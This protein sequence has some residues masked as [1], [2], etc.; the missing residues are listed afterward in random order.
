M[1]SF[2]LACLV[3]ENTAG[4][5]PCSGLRQPG[6]KPPERKFHPNACCG[7]SPYDRDTKGCCKVTNRD[8]PV[9]FTK[10]YQGCCG[11]HIIDLAG[12]GCCHSKPHNLEEQDCCDGQ[13]QDAKIFPG[14]RCQFTEWNEWSSCAATLGG[15]FQER[16]RDWLVK[17]GRP[18]SICP[19]P[20]RHP[21]YI[22]RERRDGTP[23]GTADDLAVNCLQNTAM[24]LSNGLKHAGKY[25]DLV[26]LLD[27]STSIKADNFEYAK[28]LVNNIVKSLCGGVGRYSNRV[29]VVR[30]SADV[31]IDIPFNEDMTTEDVTD[32]VSKFEYQPIQSDKH[33]GSTYTAAAMKEVYEKV[34]SKSNGWRMGT[35]PPICSGVI[36][37]GTCY[38]IPLTYVTPS[39]MD[40]VC[41]S[42][43]NEGRPAVLDNYNSYDMVQQLI[44]NTFGFPENDD[45]REGPWAGM[46]VLSN[47]KWEYHGT[48]E[49]VWSELTDPNQVE[50]CVQFAYEKHNGKSYNLRSVDCNRPRRV[51]CEQEPLSY[52]DVQTELLLITDGRSNDPN[53]LGITLEEMKRIY[54]NTDINVSA[55][56]VGRIN[57]EEIRELTSHQ[58][59]HIFYLMSWESVQKFNRIFEKVSKKFEHD[60]CLPLTVAQEDIA[61]VKWTK[62][63]KG[64]GV[65]VRADQ[66]SYNPFDLIE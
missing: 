21:D 33:K 37:D 11:E 18:G 48:R 60:A 26:I 40:E 5:L 9:V 61:W 2:L 24:S 23:E 53:N 62:A 3:S 55:I 49:D 10:L 1:K 12:Q 38:W 22:L 20:P 29:S 59:G 54:S 65:T 27:E 46:N 63:L 19:T 28:Q 57:E 34:V 47:G 8:N 39:Q 4:K 52:L 50:G 45:E 25:K 44:R 15:G 32:M 58:E 6:V 14:C 17:D 13:I 16:N 56:G 66:T 7:T 30:F 41:S 35:G 31:K 43:M 51:I 36:I 42:G 64:H